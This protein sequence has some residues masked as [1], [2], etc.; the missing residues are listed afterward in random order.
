MAV[1]GHVARRRGQGDRRALH[2]GRKLD[3]TTEAGARES[4]E[5]KHVET[6]VSCRP[7]ARS[8]MSFSSSSG[9]GSWS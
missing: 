5:V 1:D 6:H 8:S 2:E 4:V 7:N 3:L 9:S